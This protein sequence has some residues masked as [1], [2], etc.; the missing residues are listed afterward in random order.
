MRSTHS[1]LFLLTVAYANLAFSQHSIFRSAD[2]TIIDPMKYNY[3][4]IGE[5]IVIEGDIIVGTAKHNQILKGSGIP[6]IH[7]TRWPNKTVLY[8][9]NKRLSA[10]KKETVK[11]A[12]VHWKSKTNLNFLKRTTEKNYIE[13][14]PAAGTTCSSSVGRVGGKQKLN[15]A[16]RCNLGNTIHEIGHAIGL[17]HEQ[18][19][20]DRDNYV[21]IHFDKIKP[22]HSHNFDKHIVDGELLSDYDYLSI[23]HYGPHAFST[24]GSVTIE[25]LLPFP[26]G[27]REGLSAGDRAAANLMYPS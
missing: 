17:W 3:Q 24:D 23:M 13:F 18:S 16:A 25:T 4:I 19:R 7:S 15:L 8:A 26:I 22:Q 21:L 5:D 20:G 12:I 2:V 27:Q 14:M 6:A 1:F 10:D 9:F 11:Q